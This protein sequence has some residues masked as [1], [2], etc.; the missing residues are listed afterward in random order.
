[1]KKL[2]CIIVLFVCVI[3]MSACDPAT[4]YYSVDDFA[5]RVKEIELIRY[6][7]P[8]QKQFFSW[9]PDHSDD[10]VALDMSRIAVLETLDESKKDVF[11]VELT[12]YDILGTYYA[13][14]SPA[15][16]C[17]RINYTD[18][19]FDLITADYQRKSFGGYIGTFSDE[20]EVIKFIGCFSSLYYFTDLVGRYFETE[21]T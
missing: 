19:T 14:D 7:N 16:I 11:L 20:G 1:M 21:L 9:V 6:D 15:N 10:L 3:S 8:D 17:I 18:G 2:F 5:G 4:V 13:Y 12:Q